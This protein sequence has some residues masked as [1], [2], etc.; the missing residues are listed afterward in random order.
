MYPLCER[1]A[2]IASSLRRIYCN[3]SN[4]VDDEIKDGCFEI[5]DEETQVYTV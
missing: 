5:C 1:K 4:L 3:L 2:N